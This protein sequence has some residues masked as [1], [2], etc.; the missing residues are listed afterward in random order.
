[1][2]GNWK[3][4]SEKGYLYGIILSLIITYLCFLIAKCTLKVG[5]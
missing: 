4:K 5:N 1:M 2:K 3:G